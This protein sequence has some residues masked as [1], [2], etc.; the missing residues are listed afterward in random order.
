MGSRSEG[1]EVPE[2][3][4]WHGAERAEPY[5][6][7]TVSTRSEYALTFLVHRRPQ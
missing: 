3:T 5:L 2:K 6:N 1:D 7:G 4:A